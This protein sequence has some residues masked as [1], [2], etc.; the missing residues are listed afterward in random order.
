[1]AAMTDP[2]DPD[3][4]FRVLQVTPTGLMGASGPLIDVTFTSFPGLS[5]S[6]ERSPGG[7]PSNRVQQPLGT[8]PGQTFTVRLEG[9]VL[10]SEFIRIRKDTGR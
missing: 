1:L 6:V 3:S 4:F 2:T 10:Q 7:L 8:A 5:Y 9:A